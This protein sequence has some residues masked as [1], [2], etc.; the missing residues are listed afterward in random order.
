MNTVRTWFEPYADSATR[1]SFSPGADLL[2]GELMQTCISA[3]V[4]IVPLTQ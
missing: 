2:R 1:L 4:L 3:T